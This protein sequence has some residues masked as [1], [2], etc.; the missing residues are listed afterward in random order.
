ME[1]F[2]GFLLSAA[3]RMSKRAA[4]VETDVGFVNKQSGFKEKVFGRL[5]RKHPLKFYSWI[6]RTS[7]PKKFFSDAVTAEWQILNSAGRSVP[8]EL[9]LAFAN[10]FYLQ[11]FSCHLI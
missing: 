11:Q 3:V 10:S 5:N 4:N 9:R 6:R 7:T 2:V 1:S 8:A